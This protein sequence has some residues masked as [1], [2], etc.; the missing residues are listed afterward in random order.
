MAVAFEEATHKMGW[1]QALKAIGLVF[2]SLS[3]YPL[4]ALLVFGLGFF[5]AGMLAYHLIHQ[6]WFELGILTVAFGLAAWLYFKRFTPRHQTS[7]PSKGG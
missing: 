4:L 3:I 7:K 5:L 2:L 1:K 6:N